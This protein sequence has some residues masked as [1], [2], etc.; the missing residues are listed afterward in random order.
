MER[1]S[2]AKPDSLLVTEFCS[3]T[4]DARREAFSALYERYA[5]QV[6]AYLGR[7]TRHVQLAED[8]VQETFLRALKALDRFDSRSSFKTWVYCI[9]TNLFKDHVKRRSTMLQ[10]ETPDWFAREAPC[11]TP[12]QEAQQKEETGRVRAAVEALPDQYREPVILV[13]IEGL[14]YAEAAEVLVS[15]V[16]MRIHRAHLKL[17]DALKKITRLPCSPGH[18]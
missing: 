4:T 6:R 15:T 10:R 14:S 7:M 11:H 17:M 9:A 12:V 2:Q 3:G 13:R 1:G 16:R 8:L 18:S 5:G